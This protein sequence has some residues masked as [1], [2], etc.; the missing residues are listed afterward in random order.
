MPE[1]INGRWNDGVVMDM[2]Y[3]NKPSGSKQEYSE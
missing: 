3:R 2:H 1:N